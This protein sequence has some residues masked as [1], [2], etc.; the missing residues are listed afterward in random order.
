MFNKHGFKNK[1]VTNYIK[2]NKDIKRLIEKM[3]EKEKK[4]KELTKK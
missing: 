4:Y 2:R 1:L 3:K